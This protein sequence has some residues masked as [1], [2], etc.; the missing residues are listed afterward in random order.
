MLESK[1]FSSE[2]NRKK[3]IGN[4][5]RKMRKL[6]KNKKGDFASIVIALV[7]I[8]VFAVTSIV[9]SHAF[10]KAVSNLKMQEGLSNSSISVIETVEDRTIPLLDYAVFF[11]M[12][13][14][15][16]GL[17]ISS[18]Y[19]RVHPAWLVAFLIAL[20]IVIVLAGQ[21]TNIFDAISS[22]DELSSTASNFTLTNL[23]MKKTGGVPVLPTIF[24]VLG[25][26]I[27][28]VL[29]GKSRSGGLT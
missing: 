18:I 3:I 23:I 17:I 21:F 16:I 19:V 24:L 15:F 12:I 4:L 9:F 20:I 27:V 25:V 26:I 1:F 5:T 6:L 8:F 10:L 22:N 29:Y 28:V 14:L 2:N 7:I 11:I 13:A